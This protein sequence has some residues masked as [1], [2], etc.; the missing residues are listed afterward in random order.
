MTII[1]LI[2]DR[3]IRTSLTVLFVA[4]ALRELGVTDGFDF[5]AALFTVAAVL[6]VADLVRRDGVESRG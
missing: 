5:V 3:L 1:A 4:W 2:A 6:F